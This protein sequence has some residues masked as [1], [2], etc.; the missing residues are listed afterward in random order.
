VI[1]RAS[2]LARLLATIVALAVAILMVCGIGSDRGYAESSAQMTQIAMSAYVNDAPIP[3]SSAK[4]RSIAAPYAAARAVDLVAVAPRANRCVRQRSL[5]PQKPQMTPHPLVSAR[6]RRIYSGMR[7]GT[8]PMTRPRT[9]RSSDESVPTDGRPLASRGTSFAESHS[10][11]V[12][13][14]RWRI[15][16]TGSL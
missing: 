2:A 10:R 1:I 8:S 7:P 4:L 12:P 15:A 14:P 16:L 13:R 5:L 3:Y 9:E 6:I 11:A